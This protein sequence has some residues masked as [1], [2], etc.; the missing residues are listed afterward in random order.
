MR[1]FNYTG[2]KKLKHQDIDISIYEDGTQLK[3]SADLKLNGYELPGDA[4]VFI[5][6]YEQM[7]W[8]RFKF[9]KVSGIYPEESNVLSAFDD[10]EGILFRV[11]V[12]SVGDTSGQLAALAERIR[13]ALPG[14]E[15]EDIRKIPLLPVR[16]EELNGPIWRISYDDD[17]TVL[18]IEKSAGNKNSV[19]RSPYFLSL[20]YP[21]A[22]RQILLK[23]LL[24]D[25]HM[26]LDD[27]DDWRSLWLN[28]ATDISGESVPAEEP[29]DSDIELWV[30]NV[31][32]A[33]SR[34]RGVFNNFKSFWSEGEGL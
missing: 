9:G 12:I 25:R 28:F 17:A 31:V 19:A 13:P 33:Y 3:F 16:M 1:R 20:V 7:S 5:E 4:D 18:E 27:T 32:A 24:V 10:P 26:E 6:A 34:R 21:D 22:M 30:D 11:K 14:N 23:I 8:M 15:E 29:D 2:R